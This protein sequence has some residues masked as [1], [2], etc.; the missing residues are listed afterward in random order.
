MTG[1]ETGL[2]VPVVTWIAYDRITGAEIVVD[3]RT[4]NEAYHSREPLV[5]S[6]PTHDAGAEAGAEEAAAAEPSR[7][8]RS[9]ISSTRATGSKPRSSSSTPTA[10]SK[11][12]S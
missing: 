5:E 6:D 12:S 9:R 4:F 3:D 11:P 1:P 8:H 2:S 10:D 7:P